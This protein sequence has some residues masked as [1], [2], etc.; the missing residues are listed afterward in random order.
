MTSRLSSVWALTDLWPPGPGEVWSR[1]G[2]GPLVWCSTGG[3]SSQAAGRHKACCQPSPRCL[4]SAG[5]SPPPAADTEGRQGGWEWTRVTELLLLIGSHEIQ[6]NTLRL[7]IPKTKFKPF[8]VVV[9]N[10]GTNY[11]LHIKTVA[12]RQLCGICLTFAFYSYGYLLYFT[13]FYLF[14]CFYVFQV[15]KYFCTAPW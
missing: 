15:F 6:K 13:C 14:I 4:K 10:C 9:P 1:S 7:V 2:P 5:C 3:W 8:T 12:G 11:P